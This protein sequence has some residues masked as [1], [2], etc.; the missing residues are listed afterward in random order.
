LK[1]ISADLQIMQIFILR[2]L[3][4]LPNLRM[5]LWHAELRTSKR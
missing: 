2:N 3:R 1:K 4:N 5:D